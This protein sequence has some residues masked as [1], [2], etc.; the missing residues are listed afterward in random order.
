MPSEVSTVS[1]DQ[2]VEGLRRELAEARE[3]Q[4]ATAE[5]LAAISNSPTDLQRVCDT[6][7]ESIVKL[8]SGISGFVYRFD[9]Q[10]I[11]VVAHDRTVTAEALAVFYDVYPLPPSR[12]SPIAQ[13][14]LDRTVV[15]VRDFETE[16]AISPAAREMARATGHRSGL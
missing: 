3:Q 10:L 8:G 9:G 14:I 1:G 12:Q 6:I 4:A 11:H 7:V 5:I 13:A 15:H 16:P 2:L